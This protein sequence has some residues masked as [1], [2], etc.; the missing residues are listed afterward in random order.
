M[1]TFDD[2]FDSSRELSRFGCIC[3]QH[4][5]SAEHDHA[6]RTLRC[7]QVPNQPENL[8]KRY[9]GVVASALVRAMFPKDAARR[10]FLKS[11]GVSTA[12]AALSQFFPLQ[13]ATEDFAE[14][15]APEKKDHTIGL[16][17][18]T[19]ATPIDMTA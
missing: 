12:L 19:C 13:T 17:P 10:A 11:V 6:E 2:P 16:L 15:G 18:I 1:S 9:E 7:D 8:E 5:S 3:G 4:R 14:G